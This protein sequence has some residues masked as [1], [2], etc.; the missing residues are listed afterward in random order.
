M[1]GQNKYKG[2][3]DESNLDDWLCSLGYLYPVSDIQLERFEKCFDKM[4]PKLENAKIDA[5]A[6]INGTYMR[7][8]KVVN[9]ISDNFK[10][11]IEELRMV[12]RKGSKN[13]P[14]EVI[15]KM[16]NNQRKSSKN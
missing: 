8:S 12:A 10:Q 13:L 14:D 1:K 15:E 4:P 2:K 6:I 7:K 16:K 3:I 5:V 11:E 9:L